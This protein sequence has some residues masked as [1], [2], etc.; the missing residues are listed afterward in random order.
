[1]SIG[2]ESITADKQELLNFIYK[3][4]I[5]IDQLNIEKENKE[6]CL[7]GWVYRYRDQGGVIFVDL[8]DRYDIV[9]IVFEESYFKEN[10]A[11]VSAIRNEYVLAVKGIVKKRSKETINPKLKTGQIEVYVNEF[12]ILNTSKPL[13]FRLDEYSYVGEEIRLKYRYLD[14]RREEMQ[15]SIITRSKL[16]QAIRKFLEKESFLEIETPILNKSTPEGARDFLVPSRL[17]PGKFYALPQSPQVFKQILMTSGFERYYQIVKCF[18]DEDLRSDR[19][20]EF[21]Q[22]DLEMSFVNEDIIMNLMENLWRTVI[23][24]IFDV[25]L[26][27]PFP[28]IS[29]KEAMEFYGTDRPD[30]RFDM[31]LIDI[32]DLAVKS[33]FQVFKNAIQKGGRVKALCV[34]GGGILSRKEIDELTEWVKKDY[35][36]Q[37]LAWIKYEQDGLKSAISKFFSEDLLKQLANRCNAKVGDIIFFGADKE[38]I[39]ND[40]LG[41]L[42]LHL[43]KKFN[44]I[45][46]DQYACCWVVDFPLFE[47]NPETNELESVHHPFTSPVEEDLEILLNDELF[48]EKGEQI[49]SRA[50]DMVINGSE[51]GGG[52]IRIHREDLQLL[53]FKKLGIQEKEAREKFGFLLEALSFGT[54]PHG[55]IAFGID[56]MLTIFL[57]K[58]SIRDVIAFPKTQKGVCLMSETPSEVDLKQLQE[59]KIK[60]LKVK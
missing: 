7:V 23:K 28:R 17:S 47:R 1:M 12:I 24:E 16:N 53:V 22:L 8:R 33:D 25:Q 59:L 13:P 39:V 51:V 34:P 38:E 11:K 56:R 4:R 50:Y 40:T 14:L 27:N 49:R 52:S 21:T 3:N 20:P 48:K 58:E 57:K 43:A 2:I 54:P 10:Y 55:G 5:F 46:E 9:Q 30:L 37:G 18:R 41:N 35:K 45:Q 44:L 42:R 32:A 29:Y 60:I 15:R 31:K 36:A 26:P 6:V 19:Q